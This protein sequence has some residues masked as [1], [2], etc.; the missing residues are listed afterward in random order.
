MGVV[1]GFVEMEHVRLEK[2]VEPVH[3]TAPVPLFAV[4]E[5]VIRMRK[6]V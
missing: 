2:I 4:T 3:K 1:V 6:I 5:T